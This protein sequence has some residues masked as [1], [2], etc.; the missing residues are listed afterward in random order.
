MKKTTY[1]LCIIF[2]IYSIFILSLGS[3]NF[4]SLTC[5]F[6]SIT[7]LSIN[8][9]KNK[10]LKILFKFS[11]ISYLS[12][13]ILFAFFLF[14][15]VKYEVNTDNNIDSIIVL[16]AG[17][18]NKD[19]LSNSGKLRLNKAIQY[20]KKLPNTNIYLTGGKGFNNHI[21]E[22]I[23]GKKYLISNGIP[24]NKIYMEE[25]STSTKENLYYISSVIKNS[26]TGDKKFLLIT[27]DFH[28]VRSKL[29]ANHLG[30]EIIPL[31]S[32]SP[33]YNLP[34]NLFREAFAFV[35]TIIFDLK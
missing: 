33:I 24:E 35:K 8:K 32:K 30:L 14:L 7:M 20:Y 10:K 29:I 18:T 3:I 11:I 34:I 15:N 12:F 16:G 9:I 21:S 13:I 17:L 4:G 27:S 31:A 2:F 19:E 28:I 26:K 25:L 5:L 1:F 6:L 23:A 22:A